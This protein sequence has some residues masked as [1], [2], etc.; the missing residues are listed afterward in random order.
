MASSYPHS[1]A[2]CRWF[3]NRRDCIW[4]H[5]PTIYTANKQWDVNL[6]A[7]TRCN[8]LL[9]THL[10]HPS[11][12]WFCHGG[13]NAPFVRAATWNCSLFPTHC[14]VTMTAK[15]GTK[16]ERWSWIWWRSPRVKAQHPHS[17]TLAQPIHSAT[18]QALNQSYGLAN[19]CSDKDSRLMRAHDAESEEMLPLVSVCAFILN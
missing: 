10:Q 5:K 11:F 18:K 15:P 9:L 3:S 7:L 1:M 4:K 12:A 16:R 17:V 14:W 8:L 2:P 13:A 6:N 19:R